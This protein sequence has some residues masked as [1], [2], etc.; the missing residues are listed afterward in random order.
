MPTLSSPQPAIMVPMK[1]AEFLGQA[2]H[3]IFPRA[4]WGWFVVRYG[5]RAAGL[6]NRVRSA[7][8]ATNRRAVPAP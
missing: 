8:H 7:S 5:T 2:C 6:G 3:G 4:G 1:G